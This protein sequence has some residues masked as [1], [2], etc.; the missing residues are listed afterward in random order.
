MKW[1]FIVI[2]IVIALSAVLVIGCSKTQ[3]SSNPN[4]VQTKQTGQK[5]KAKQQKKKKG[6]SR[7]LVN[8]LDMTQKDFNAERKSGKS[9]VEIAQEKNKTEQQVID[10]LIQK[11]EE[12]LKKKNPNTTQDQLNQKK[13]VWTKAI[14]KQIEYKKGA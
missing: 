5:Q 10:Y 7:S 1:K 4:Q 3:S 2:S 12:S 8:F 14:T 9:I 6:I 13:Q 11:R